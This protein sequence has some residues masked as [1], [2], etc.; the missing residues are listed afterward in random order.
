MIGLNSTSE[1]NF[2]QEEQLTQL[3]AETGAYKAGIQ[4][5]KY[6][7]VQNL[8][9]FKLT[10]PTG[11]IMGHFIPLSLKKCNITPVQMSKEAFF[12][13]TGQKA[14][15]LVK[16]ARRD[17]S[18]KIADM[19]QRCSLDMTKNT[20]QEVQVM[21]TKL[22]S[23]AKIPP[24][25]VPSHPSGQT[26][27]DK[28]NLLSNLNGILVG[29][30]LFKNKLNIDIQVLAE[31]QAKDD[32]YTKI[33]ANLK[34]HTHKD[35]SFVLDH[36]NILFKKSRVYNQV[37]HRLCLPV[38]LAK[39]VLTNLH[40]RKF[41]PSR[42]TLLQMY[43]SVFFTPDIEKLTKEI[44]NSCI[45]CMLNQRHRKITITGSKRTDTTMT[46]GY[47]WNMDIAYMKRSK[48]GFK[49][50][51]VM[52][53]T[54][55]NYTSLL[56][57]RSIHVNSMIAA[58]QLFLSIMPKPSVVITDY[59]SEYSLQ[60]TNFLSSMDILHK[61]AMPRRSQQQGTVEKSISIMRAV[62]NRIQATEMKQW[63]ELLPRVQNA[64][65]GMHP[66]GSKFSRTHLL[67]SPFM[68]NS[69]LLGSK[70]PVVTQKEALQ[71]EY[72]RRAKSLHKQS[73]EK[74]SN[75][76]SSFVNGQFVVLRTTDKNT[77]S[78]RQGDIFKVTKVEKDGMAITI[79]NL[80]TG[81]H[82]V[83]PFSFITGIDLDKLT[84]IDYGIPD[85]FERLKK[86]NYK[87]RNWSQ[88]GNRKKKINI[89]EDQTI[90]GDPPTQKEDE[91]LPQDHGCSEEDEGAHQHEEDEEEQNVEHDPKSGDLRSNT[92]VT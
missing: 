78:P 87:N 55:T 57:L 85:L 76:S 65:N 25:C 73:Q 50:I 46:P 2:E 33:I 80:R 27:L 13:L 22:C 43:N 19:L 36:E 10:I 41:H 90:F 81:G 70:Y 72:E 18:D 75:K 39:Q 5:F 74:L 31:I 42:S 53:E 9:N 20:T 84:K 17:I 12:Q 1:M 69:P 61:G 23:M 47:C 14:T 38:Y 15:A 59:G 11:T 67:F 24:N 26:S 49:Y 51:L 7:D 16:E 63:P 86:L 83:V 35:N 91:D 82:K 88:P 54:M 77:P 92:M 58:V 79:T 68:T 28:G 3:I 4:T 89:M 52:T 56:P 66:G 71:G 34:K 64:I 30:Y 8:S 32:S 37:V 62:I 6:M 21:A 48:S 45:L 44:S 29:Q 40:A 60:F